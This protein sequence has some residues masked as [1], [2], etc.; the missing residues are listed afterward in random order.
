MTNEKRLENCQGM[1]THCFGPVAYDPNN[2]WV[3]QVKIDD[4]VFLVCIQSGHVFGYSRYGNVPQ[5]YAEIDHNEKC[6]PPKIKVGPTDLDSIKKA[7][8]SDV[9]LLDDTLVKTTRE[10]YDKISSPNY[11]VEHR[12][13]VNVVVNTCGDTPSID[14]VKEM[15]KTVFNETIDNQEAQRL[16]N[17]A[18]EQRK[19]ESSLPTPAQQ[20]RDLQMIR[21]GMEIG[22]ND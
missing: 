2:R 10:F 15:I 19:F 16:I 6:Y 17:S 13:K 21:L 9:E 8:T 22:N 5:F 1:L 18:V 12:E 11:F 14:G 3:C 4:K 7:T 20:E